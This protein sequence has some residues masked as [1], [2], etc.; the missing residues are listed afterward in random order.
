M[1]VKELKELL[2]DAPDDMPVMVAVENHLNPGMFAFAEACSG[3]T[4]ISELGFGKDGVEVN[5]SVFL[6][7]PHGFGVSEKEEENEGGTIPE[8]N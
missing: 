8:L 4:G 5:E 7:L 3:E 1:L 2:A 6:I